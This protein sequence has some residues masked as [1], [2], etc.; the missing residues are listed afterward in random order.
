MFLWPA[1]AGV[2]VENMRHN[3]RLVLGLVLLLAALVLSA[4]SRSGQSSPGVA[5]IDG[6]RAVE[7]PANSAVQSSRQS[8]TAG[9]LASEAGTSKRTANAA[10]LTDEEIA[11]VFT[12]C[13]RDHGFD[14]PDPVLHADGSV[15]MG[16]L[17]ESMTED[18]RYETK[19]KKAFEDC[20]PL[21]EGATFSSK[22]SPE[23]EIEIQDKLLEFAQCLRDKG[24]DV[25][26]PDF[27]GD[28]KASMKPMIANLKGPD[29][30]VQESV[31]SCNELIFGAGKSGK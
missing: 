6:S 24:F 20:L 4:C 29:S 27:S 7:P 15:D 17:K 25:P 31:D 12:E 5:R 10:K 30:R 28:P 22:A 2:I 9:Q 16:R 1:P 8:D 19:S 21:L 18:P 11:T 26:D 13:L 14:I 23:D 3:R